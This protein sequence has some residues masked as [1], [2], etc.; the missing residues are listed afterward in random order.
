MPHTIVLYLPCSKSAIGKRGKRY[1]LLTIHGIDSNSVI[2]DHNFALAS[3]R[4]WSFLDFEWIALGLRDPCCFVRHID[5]A[6]AKGWS[7]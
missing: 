4:H 3:F 7:D 1:E 5:V 2:L 6:T